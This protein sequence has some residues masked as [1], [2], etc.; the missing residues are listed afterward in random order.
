MT[1]E[2][3]LEVHLTVENYLRA[4]FGIS[5]YQTKDDLVVSNVDYPGSQLIASHSK[6]KHFG[7]STKNPQK[8]GC[9]IDMGQVVVSL[10]GK[11]ESIINTQDI[12]IPGEHNLENAC[13]ATMAAKLIGIPN[14]IIAQVLAQFKGLSHR[15]EFVREVGGVRYFDDSFATSPDPTIAAIKAFKSPKILILGGSFKNSDFTSLGKLI[16]QDQSVQGIIGIGLEWPRIKKTLGNS[17]T[18]KMVEGCTS[19]EEVVK[20]ASKI[21]KPGDVVV[22]SPSCASFD[23]FKNYKDRGEQFKKY[24][25]EI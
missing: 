22:L 9:F 12:F 1:S 10:Q 2:D 3:H 11:V 7:I 19:M 8:E 15:L 13:A 21:A 23:M 6:G 18:I 25:G 24:V 20:E 5:R 4:K 14:Q 16:S 17:K